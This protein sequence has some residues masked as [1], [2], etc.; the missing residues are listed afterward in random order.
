MRLGIERTRADHSAAT[1]EVLRELASFFDGLPPHVAA[2]AE[3]QSLIYGA[4]QRYSLEKFAAGVAALAALDR[5]EPPS[6]SEADDEL[7]SLV[8]H[9]AEAHEWEPLEAFARHLHKLPITGRALERILAQ[10]VAV[11]LMD[12]DAEGAR[13]L[14]PLVPV[15]ITWDILAYNLACAAAMRTDRAATF[16]FTERSLVL[17]KSPDQFLGDTDFAAFH[18]DAEFLALLDKHR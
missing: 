3:V 1:L 10:L 4:A 5:Y 18:D 9:F 14:E 17:G 6:P 8:A 13:A 2:S 16:T 15:E 11:T 12:R 7:A